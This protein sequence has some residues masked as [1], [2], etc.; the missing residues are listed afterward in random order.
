MKI[1]IDL[2][3]LYTDQTN[4]VDLSEYG[5][6]EETFNS[7]DEEEQK[8]WLFENVTVNYDSPCWVI[9]KIEEV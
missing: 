2:A 1:K 6:D 5:M 9:E 7:M 3:V 8:E 4:T